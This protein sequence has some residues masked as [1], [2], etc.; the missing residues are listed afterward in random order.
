ERSGLSPSVRRKRPRRRALTTAATG[1]SDASYCRTK[2]DIITSSKSSRGLRYRLA[3]SGA[4][5]AQPGHRYAERSGLSPSVRRKRPRRPALTTAATRAS[6]ASYCRTKF[7]I[8][9]SSKSSRG[10]RHRL[11]LSGAPLAQ[12]GHRYAERSGLSPSVRRKSPR[13][14]SLTTAATRASDAS[15]CRTKFDIITS[16]KSSRGLR[17]RLAL[18]G[19]PLAQPGHRS[20]ERS[21]LSPSVRRKQPRR[22]ALSTAATRASDASYC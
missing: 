1:A 6:D 12:P 4:P 17:H 7:D 16:S 14:P 10:L 22:P 20:A 11:A 21:G 8:I 15:Y 9:T 5:L 2:F 13:R 18:S 19:A 3:L